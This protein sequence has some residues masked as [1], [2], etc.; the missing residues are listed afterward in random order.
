V[1][2]PAFA[3]LS[4]PLMVLS[5]LSMLLT[6]WSMPLVFGVA[7]TVAVEA[8]A[9]VTPAGELAPCV[10]VLLRCTAPHPATATTARPHKT[11]FL[12]DE[13][14]VIGSVSLGRLGDAFHPTIPSTAEPE[15]ER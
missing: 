10:A 15:T 11:L 1:L 2:N 5:W 12:S 9:E 3:A 14:W 13:R 7:V 8:G 4:W 6:C